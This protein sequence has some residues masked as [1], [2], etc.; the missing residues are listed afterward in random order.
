MIE[1]VRNFFTGGHF[2][3]T[4]EL[5]NILNN[6]VDRAVSAEVVTLA[7]NTTLTEEDCGKVF[8]INEDGIV[9]SLP[10][11]KAGLKYTFINIKAAGTAGFSVS[12]V[13]ADGISGTFTL[14]ASVVVDAGVVNK[15]ITNTKSSATAGDCVEII[16]TGIT[17]TTAWIVK[18]STGIWAAQG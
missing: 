15:D 5:K 16:G 4:M 18:S 1:K 2:G 12:P 7:A 6:I 8:L 14:A 17:G 13:A 10:A 9:V 3:D 11:T